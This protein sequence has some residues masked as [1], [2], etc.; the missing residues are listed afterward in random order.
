MRERDG[1]SQKDGKRDAERERERKKKRKSE[2]CCPALLRCG[3]G[4]QKRSC[5]GLIE[6]LYMTNS[7]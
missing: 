4:A 5:R 1:E 2:I 3:E 6:C 7:C